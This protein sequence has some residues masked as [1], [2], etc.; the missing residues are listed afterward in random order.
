MGKIVRQRVVFS[1]GGSSDP[2]VWISQAEYDALSEE[3][4]MSGTTYYVYDADSDLDVDA[5][6]IP[7]TSENYE[8]T[9]VGDALEEVNES[10]KPYSI[11]DFTAGDVTNNYSWVERCGAL[12]IV[13]LWCTCIPY[14][15]P[16]LLSGLPATQGNSIGI[17]LGTGA[18]S[19]VSLSSDGSISVASSGTTEGVASVI[20][21]TFSYFTNEK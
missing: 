1:G 5:S 9:N 7:F 14:N 11:L 8:A 15:K 18:P 19:L 12:V 6:D 4:Q 17:Y 3:E 13:H 10:L 21:G 2:G 16:T 20:A